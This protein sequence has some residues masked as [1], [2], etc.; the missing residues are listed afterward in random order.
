MIRLDDH[1]RF[2]TLEILFEPQ[3]YAQALGVHLSGGLNRIPHTSQT[4]GGGG[5]AGGVGG[6]TQPGSAGGLGSSGSFRDANFSLSSTGTFRSN[7]NAASNIQIDLSTNDLLGVQLL[8]YHSL[9]M[10]DAFLRKELLKNIVLA[11]GTSM[12]KGFGERIKR[13]LAALIDAA[14]NQQ[15]AAA[16]S[17]SATPELSLSVGADGSP[18]AAAAAAGGAASA[19]NI[20]TDSQ[21]KYAA[22]IG[23]SMYASLPTFAI[24]KITAEQYKRDEH[25]VSKKF[26]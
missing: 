1:C 12:A 6:Q 23:A 25:S 5:S 8:L 3:T 17:H 18:S 4:H 7:N 13:E 16:A 26:F 14:E 2:N 10:C 22:W 19:L 20:I 11:G 24:I 21:R 15:A 9:H